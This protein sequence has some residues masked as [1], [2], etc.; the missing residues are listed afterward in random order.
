MALREAISFCRTCTGG[1]GVRLTIDQ[2][3]RIVSIRGDRDNRLTAGFACF[4]GLQAEEAHHGEKRLLRPMKRMPDGSFRHIALEDA[5]REISERLGSIVDQDGADAVAVF[6]GNGANMNAPTTS[7]QR[8]FLAAIG[9][10]QYFTSITIDQPSKFVSVGR[11]GAWLPGLQAFDDMDICLLIGINPLV[12]LGAPGILSFDPVKQLKQAK[13][14]GLK[15]IVIDPRKTETAQFA[16]LA[17]QPLPGQDAAIAGGILRIILEE[18]WE[19]KEFCARFVDP[20][21]LA[22]L[23]K[24]IAPLTEEHVEARAGLL[25]GQLRVVAEMFGRDGRTGAAYAGT[26]TDMAPFSNLAQQMVDCLN[27]ICGRFLRAGDAIHAV[28]AVIPRYPIHERV[29]PPTRPW[30]QDG[31][32]RIRGVNNFFGERC[33]GTLAEEILTPGEGQIRALIVDGGNPLTSLPDQQSA[34]K[35]LASLELLVSIDPWETPTTRLAHYVLPPTMQFERHD[36]QFH[37]KPGYAFWPGAWGIYTPPVISPPAGSEVVDDWYVFWSLAARL[38]HQLTFNGRQKLSSERPPTAEEL[39]SIYLADA[40]YTLDDLKDHPHGLML[41]MDGVV[42]QPALDGDIGRFDVMAPDVAEEM[43]RFLHSAAAEGGWRRDGKTYDYLVTTRRHRDFFNSTGVNIHSILARSP[44][45][46]AFFNP[47]DLVAM[48]IAA[49]DLIELESAHGRVRAVAG[50]DPDLRAGVISMSHGWG[51]LPDEEEDPALR[52]S[53][54]NRLIDADRNFEAICA[55]PHMS[56][57]P[58]NVAKLVQPVMPLQ[59]ELF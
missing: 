16:D 19:D 4:K 45:N 39:I 11:M 43:E 18:G 7:A 48:D 38:G 30:D 14:R 51:G 29:I 3:D 1:C 28:D 24:A 59:Q 58:V 5:L 34:H 25:P 12:S 20:D 36:I 10:R 27:V 41:D 52:G 40:Q 6:C 55:M 42:V 49:G 54:V 21:S 33:S 37:L 9:S 23:R 44:N 13:A 22:R 15:L 47:A 26:G 53:A 35:A 56:A 50:V 17:L 2:D 8:D 32:S 57:I 31:P 46:P